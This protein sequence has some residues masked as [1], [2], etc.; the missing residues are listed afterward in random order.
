MY[1]KINLIGVYTF[2]VITF[3]F[4]FVFKLNIPQLLTV[5][6]VSYIIFIFL[7]FVKLKK[8][9]NLILSA[10][11]IFETVFFVYS[12]MAAF[13]FV[14]DGYKPRVDFFLIDYDTILKTLYLYFN[15]NCI[16]IILVF[17]FKGPRYIEMKDEIR[18]I[19]I[20][21]N[22]KVDIWDIIAL[23]LVA[24]FLYLHFRNGL[25]IFSTYI[26]D[27][28][29]IVNSGINSYIYIYMI[30]YS[31]VKIVNLVYS[32]KRRTLK[33]I[34]VIILVVS[35][36]GISLL[37]DRRNII[38]LIIMLVMAFF[39]KN[40]KVGLKKILMIVMVL[41]V[42]LSFGFFRTGATFDKND[43]NEFVYMSTGEF[44]LSHYVSEYYIN[45]HDNL[46][47]GRTYYFDTFTKLIPRVFYPN[48]P[49]D[50]SMLF[51]KEA[52]TNVGFA[53]NPVA[54]GIIN[55]GIIGSMIVVPVVIIFY[56]FLAYKLAKRNVLNYI[57]I[58]A[59]SINIFRGFFA[60]TAFALFVMVIL[61]SLMTEHYKIRR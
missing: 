27:L 42:F 38:N 26:R 4:N 51:Y 35:F 3:F 45:N 8:F 18:K 24:Y 33:N 7:A 60:N 31:F 57:A 48:K 41:L 14:L 16:Y 39:T 5:Y 17:L 12:V 6:L 37:T 34:L 29:N 22:K 44:I 47:Y 20:F 59:Y 52:N 50:L 61:I 25:S 54:E 10:E 11:V 55:F 58:C 32:D 21:S 49:E 40:K 46:L 28:R 56:V 19:T 1:P 30:I 13:M 9:K 23:V 53:F 43:I 15:I 36:W 2:L